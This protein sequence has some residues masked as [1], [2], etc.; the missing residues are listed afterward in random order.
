MHNYKELKVWQKSRILVKEVYVALSSFP[1]DEKY[2]IISQ[3]KRAAIS[4]PTNISEG[5][6]RNTVADLSRFLDISYS[7]AFELENLLILSCDLS[8][9]SPEKFGW[10]SGMVREVQK[11][12]F[13]LKNKISS[14]ILAEPEVEYLN[15]LDT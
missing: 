12:I 4:I 10:L 1:A 3:I 5:C 11:M 2:G 7:S 8:L 9:L 6:G 15:S 13:G 14:S